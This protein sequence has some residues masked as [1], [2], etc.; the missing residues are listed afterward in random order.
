MGTI[1]PTAIF[2][3]VILSGARIS[4]ATLHNFNEVIRLDVKIGDS[5]I[6]E[7]S[8][9]VIP[10]VVG[11]IKEKRPTDAGEIVPPEKCPVC[12]QRAEQVVGEVAYM[13]TNP[14]CPA[15]VRERVKHFVSRQAFDIEGLGEEIAA[16]FIELGFLRD[17]SDIFLLK[18]HE[19]ELKELERFGEKSVNNLLKAIEKASKIEYWRFINAIGIRYVGEQTARILADTFQPFAAFMEA[20]EEILMSAREVGETVARSIR[21]FF[22]NPGSRSMLKRLFANGVEII[23]PEKIGAADSPIAGM[24]VVFTGKA[25][26][27][28]REEF[29]EIVRKHGGTPSESVSGNT[30]ILVAGENA[31]SK[32]DKAKKFGVKIV[33]PKDFLEL[34]KLSE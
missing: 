14:E 22:D 30:S 26:G 5:I 7:R 2:D 9:D 21:A 3:P 29:K 27:F 31:G 19:S 34:L 18:N 28:T 8:G 16:R 6:V 10:K 32:L 1:T 17:A 15:V 23:Y 33:S 20:P 13:C 12:G 4:R 25:D 11:V 24:T